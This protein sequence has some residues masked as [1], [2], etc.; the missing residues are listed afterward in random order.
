MPTG[1]VNP[2]ARPLRVVII[3]DYDEDAILLQRHLSR[4]G[5]AVHARR[6]QTAAELLET[7]Q[8]PDPWDLVIADYTLPSFGARDALKLIQESG[9]DIPFII[10]SG[11]I[12]EVSAVNAMR[13]VLPFLSRSGG[14]DLRP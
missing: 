13:V 12:D 1:S 8:D 9:I 4:A 2:A 11:T 7:M 3:E 5:Y 6:V 14:R 10:V